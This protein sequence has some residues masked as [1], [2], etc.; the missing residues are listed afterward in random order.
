MTDEHWEIA[1]EALRRVCDPKKFSFRTTG[2]IKPLEGVI[3]Q[4]R[5]VRAIEFGLEMKG[6]GYNIFVAGSEGTGKKTIVGQIAAECTRKMPAPCDW[7]LVNNQK[8]EGYFDVCSARGLTGRQGVIIPKANENNL[9][10]RK[11]V[12]DAVRRGKFH[13]YRVQTVE[14]GLK[15]L[16][17]KTVGAPDAAGRYDEGGLYGM[18]QKALEEYTRLAARLRHPDDETD[19][20]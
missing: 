1:P 3:G 12:V 15:I 8:I 4:A 14:E 17:G 13:V 9:M 16:T 18:A 19:V 5:A 6:A 10:L 2:E 7:C 20:M 11:D